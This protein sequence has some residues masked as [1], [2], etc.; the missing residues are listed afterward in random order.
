MIA[1]RM[2]RG[3]IEVKSWCVIGGKTLTFGKSVKRTRI[4]YIAVFPHGPS[5]YPMMDTLRYACRAE[6]AMIHYIPDAWTR[7]CCMYDCKAD[8]SQED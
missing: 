8:R 5:E 4:S 2:T 3:F 7:R 1:K 6:K